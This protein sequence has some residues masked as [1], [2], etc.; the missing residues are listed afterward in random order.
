MMDRSHEPALEFT[1]LRPEH[2]QAL[3]DFFGKLVAVGA[4]TFFHPH[5]FNAKEADRIANYSGSDYYCA[6]FRKGSMVA[7]AMLRGWDDGFKVPSA[8]LAV[9][10]DWQGQGL[11]RI[12]MEVLHA[13][14][15][16][17]GQHRIRLSVYPDNRRAVALYKSLGYTFSL[18]RPDRLIGTIELPA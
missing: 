4:G 10:P 15:L 9:H 6:G 2:T 8:G 5:E 3:A 18:E 14:V 12:T 11:G 17:R 1:R 13:E 16:S 7:Y